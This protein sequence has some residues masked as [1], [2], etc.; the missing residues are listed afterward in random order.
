MLMNSKKYFG[1]IKDKALS[2]STPK[3]SS[4]FVNTHRQLN[5]PTL[6][7]LFDNRTKA[8]QERKKV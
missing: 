8:K 7:W 6:L 3:I 2:Q 1:I 5:L 4:K